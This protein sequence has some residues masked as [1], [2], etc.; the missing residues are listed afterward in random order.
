MIKSLR[1]L[2][3][4]RKRPPAPVPRIPAWSELGLAAIAIHIADASGP[5]ARKG[6]AEA[7]RLRP[8]WRIVP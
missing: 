8:D 2:L 5:R 4:R 7:T 3:R 1:A 6:W